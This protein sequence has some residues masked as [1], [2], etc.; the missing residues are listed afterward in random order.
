MILRDADLSWRNSYCLP[1]TARYF[2]S[3]HSEEELKD[4]L[5]WAAAKRLPVHVLGG[6]SN[7]LFSHNV[8]EGLVV[9][10]DNRFLKFNGSRITAGC[11]VDSSLFAAAACCHGLE[12]A[13]FLYGLPGTLGGALYMNARAYDR[14]M[15]QIVRRAKVMDMKGNIIEI[16]AEDMA[17]DYKDSWF[18]HHDCIIL[19]AEFDLAPGEK[20]AISAE[21]ERNIRSRREKGHYDYPSCGSVFKNPY[22]LG[23]PAGKLVEDAGLKGAASGNAEIFT[24]HGNFIVNKG[25][26]EAVDILAL[27]KT[28]KE[29]IRKSKDYDLETEVEIW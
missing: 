11:G 12:G 2:Y 7:V 15:S 10:A 19:S 1:A 14:S 23:I 18:Q 8:I 3:Y 25:G 21:M 20:E 17:F 26:A 28:V 22:D 4:V 16:Q 5:A 24:K 6:G 13:E 29:H 27:I 9:A